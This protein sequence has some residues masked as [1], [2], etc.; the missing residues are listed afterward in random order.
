MLWDPRHDDAV[1]TGV[2]PGSTVLVCDK[3]LGVQEL[4]EGTTANITSDCG[5]QV[6]KHCPGKVL[7]M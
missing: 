2:V 3:L 5:F 7:K 1:G 6:W 4:V